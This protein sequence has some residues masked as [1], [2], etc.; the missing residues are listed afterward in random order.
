V[1][2]HDIETI[3]QAEERETFF[4]VVDQ[5][6]EGGDVECSN[7]GYIS[8]KNAVHDRDQRSLGLSSCRWSNDE[9]IISGR[10]L[11]IGVFLDRTQFIPSQPVG[12]DFANTIMEEGKGVHILCLD[13]TDEC[14][15]FSEKRLNKLPEEEKKKS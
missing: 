2:L 4:L 9:D 14:L 5:G 1:P 6:L 8:A 10:N 12:E 13:R 15:V 11:H 3:R 7:S